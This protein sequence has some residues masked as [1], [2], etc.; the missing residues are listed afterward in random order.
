MWVDGFEN[1]ES[2]KWLK[3]SLAS[4]GLFVGSLEVSH[5]LLD[6]G[7]CTSS[8]P[9]FFCRLPKTHSQP[10]ASC[11]SPP[12]ASPDGLVGQNLR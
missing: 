10:L 3:C 6:L 4:C 2:G 9:S 1:F 7:G 8:L 5:G 11:G 12:L